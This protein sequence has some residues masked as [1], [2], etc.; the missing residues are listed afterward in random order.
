[1]ATV[2]DIL[3]GSVPKLDMSGG[4]WAIFSLYFQTTIKRKGLWGHFNGSVSCSVLSSP[5]QSSTPPA[6]SVM[7]WRNI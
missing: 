6:L 4:N 2:N 5:V 3:S 7:T 1:M